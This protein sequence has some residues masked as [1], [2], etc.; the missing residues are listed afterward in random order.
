MRLSLV[1]Q[2]SGFAS[3]TATR[4]SASRCPQLPRGAIRL[5]RLADPGEA[6]V[7]TNSTLRFDDSVASQGARVEGGG[8]G[9]ICRVELQVED[10]VGAISGSHVAQLDHRPASKNHR[11]GLVG[12]TQPRP[13]RPCSPHSLVP[14][15]RLSGRRIAGTRGPG[16]SRASTLGAPQGGLEHSRASRRRPHILTP[17]RS[18]TA[19][20]VNQSNWSRPI[21]RLDVLLEQTSSAEPARRSSSIPRLLTIPFA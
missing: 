20:T 19:S 17:V 18:Q 11:F 5:D 1:P 16:R 10:R 9:E 7:W 3:S 14:R 8:A 6:P 12:S 15:L 21:D 2:G 13:A 4:L